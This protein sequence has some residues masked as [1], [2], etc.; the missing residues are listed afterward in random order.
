MRQPSITIV[1][2]GFGGI[3]TAIDLTR[4]G[5]RD[6][7]ILEKGPGVGGVWREND[8]PNAACDVP[9]S[10]Y[11]WSF[12]PN[13]GWPHRYSHQDE[14]LAYIERTAREHGVLDLVRTGVEVTGASYDVTSQSWHVETADGGSLDTDVLITC[15]G[16]LSRPAMPA[17]PGIDSFTGPAFHSAEWDHSVDL[18]GKRVAV[19]GTGASAIQFVPAIAPDVAHLTV[20]QRSAPWIAPKLNIEYSPT[21]QRVYR[22]WPLSQAFGRGL[23]W[24]V[25]ELFNTTFTSDNVLR[26]TV[27]IGCKGQL[28]RQVRDADLR[29]KLTPTDEFGCKRVLWSNEWYPALTRDNVDVVTEPVVEVLPHGVRDRAGVEH[30]VDVVIYGTGFAATEF[31][32]PMAITGVDGVS[33][34]DRWKDGARAYLGLCVPDFPNLFVVYGPNTNLGGSSI[35]GMLEAGSG[36]VVSML[37]AADRAGARSIAVRPEA[38][39]RYDEEMQSRLADSVWVSCVNWYHE[40]GGRISTNWPGQVKEYQDRCADLD[41]ADFELV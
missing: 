16:Q 20:F 38:E 3:G 11:S 32:A 31:L 1:G 24:H 25:T 13:P 37:Q 35:I 36:A 15:V 17:I 5:F 22:R 6:V 27:E 28:R 9:S 40:N 23:T 2:A 33:L 30:E 8:Y 19:L 41:L 14:I 10:L 7:T 21:R 39:Q 12:A 29:R 18:T 34:E 4:A 26:K